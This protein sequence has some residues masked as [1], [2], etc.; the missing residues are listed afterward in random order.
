MVLSNEPLSG[1]VG[2]VGAEGLAVAEKSPTRNCILRRLAPPLLKES[3]AMESS[4][5]LSMRPLTLMLVTML[6]YLLKKRPKSKKG[7]RR[8]TLTP[9][10]E[11]MT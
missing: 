6:I 1:G 9:F 2:G 5:H 11:R 8:L 3:R 7:L 10:K 4:I